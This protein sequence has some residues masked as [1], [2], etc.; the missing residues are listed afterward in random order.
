[1]A[2]VRKIFLG[3]LFFTTILPGILSAASR[4]LRIKAA[5]SPHF[6]QNLEWE[7]DIRDRLIFLNK[8]FEPLF[9]IHF[10]VAQYIDW[11]PQDEMRE[12]DLLM[13]ELRSFIPLGEEE[14]IIGFHKMSQPFSKDKVEDIDTVGSAQFFRGFIVIRDP[15]HELNETQQEVVLVHEAAHLF[16]AVHTGDPKAIMHSSVPQA[17]TLDL[18]PDTRQ[19]INQTREVDFTQGLPSLRDDAVNQLIQIYEQQIRQ[20]PHSDFYYQLGKFYQHLKQ[21]AKAA[22]VWEEALRYQYE[23]PY[24]HHELGFH[25]YFGGRYQ[26][27]VRELGSAIA[28]LV[29]PSQR[30]QKAN[31]LN[32]LGTAYYESGNTDQAIFNWLKGLSS[33]PDNFELQGNLAV[34]YMESNNLEKGVAELEKLAAKNPHDVTTLSNLGAAYLRSKKPEKAV[35]YFQMALDEKSLEAPQA[36]KQTNAHAASLIDEIPE[37]AVLINLGSAYLD[38]KK[39][40]EA[41][42]AFETSKSLDSKNF[43]VHKN[44][45]Q[46]Y[47]LSENFEKAIEEVNKAIGFKKDDPYLYAFLGQSY[48][49]LG[50][51]TEAIQAAKEGLKYTKKDQ[52]EASLRRNLGILY[53]QEKRFAEAVEEF[54]SALNIQWKD[55]ETH[56]HLGIVQAQAGNMND[57]RRSLKNALVIDPSHAEAKKILSSLPAE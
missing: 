12:T 33:D 21:D 38:L 17:P 18:D 57:A 22:S 24:I 41:V 53:A 5:V 40:P 47:I 50:K 42:E 10:S 16:G 4:E 30:K 15:F 14:V 39:Y 25:Y 45:A 8:I 23:N 9:S 20:N 36:A 56:M 31:A 49:T 52:F 11:K 28:H 6:K 55:A 37:A 48:S 54:R 27:A 34:A 13:E 35:E 32:F 2:S 1:M 29:L 46:A 44:L 7:K 26:L 51:K 43:E 3:I 19:I